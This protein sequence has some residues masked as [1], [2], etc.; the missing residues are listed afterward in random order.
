MRKARGLYNIA[1]RLWRAYGRTA[2][3]LGLVLERC[4]IVARWAAVVDE[5][6]TAALASV[7]GSDE[8]GR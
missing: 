7:I 2:S 6:T 8:G 4:E 5:S 1:G 3:G